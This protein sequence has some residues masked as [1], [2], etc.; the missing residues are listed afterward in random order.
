[1][2]DLLRSM[3]GE[4]ESLVPVNNEIAIAKKYVDI[5]S[6][7]LDNRLRVD[8]DIGKFPR[9]AVMPVLMLQPLLENA[10]HHGVEPN[11]AGGV[12]GVRLWEDGDTLHIAVTNSIARTRSK[13]S[14]ARSGDNTLDSLRARLAS[15]YGQA[16]SLEATEDRDRFTALVRIPTRGGNP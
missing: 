14:A 9:K 6:L 2:A 3:L 7:R 4:S 13:G 12:I 5:E 8:W 15:H 11:P 16:A 10:I 1:M